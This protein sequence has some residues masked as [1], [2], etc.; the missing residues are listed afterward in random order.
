ML[1][2]A[3]AQDRFGHRPLVSLRPSRDDSQ[4]FLGH[5][6][7]RHGHGAGSGCGGILGDKDDATRLAVESVDQRDLS[8]SGDLVGKK[9]AKPV[10][11]RHG[12][13]R[14]ARVNEQE[15]GLVDGNQVRGLPE[16]PE[17]SFSGRLIRER[18]RFICERHDPSRQSLPHLRHPSR[19]RP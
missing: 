4:I 7:A 2:F 10:P 8:S 12:A 13:A 16:N 18:H 11:E 9:L 3:E 15:G 6:T 14:L 5:I 19:R 17:R 1:H